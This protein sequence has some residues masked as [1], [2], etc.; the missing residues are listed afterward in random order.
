MENG[1]PSKGIRPVKQN[2]GAWGGFRREK[3]GP[4]RIQYYNELEGAKHM[5]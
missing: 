2:R 4:G 5:M 3:M 1:N